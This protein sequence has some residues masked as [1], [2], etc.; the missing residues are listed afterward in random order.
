V[1]FTAK[2]YEKYPME[3]SLRYAID[4]SNAEALFPRLK[5]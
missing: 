2:Q 3:S 5:S 4:R 1:S